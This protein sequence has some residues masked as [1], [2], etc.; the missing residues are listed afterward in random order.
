MAKKSSTGTIFTVAL[1][2]VGGYFAYENWAAISAW[3]NTIIPMPTAGAATAS[4]FY[5][6]SPVPTSYSTSQTFVD[7][8]GNQWQFST[9]TGAWVIAAPGPTAVSPSAGT[10]VSTVPQ[11]V[12]APAAAAPVTASPVVSVAQP[13]APLVQW[14]APSPAPAAPAS[15]GTLVATGPSEFPTAPIIVTSYTTPPGSTQPVATRVNP[16]YGMPHYRGY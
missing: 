2:G 9:Q 14:G 10:V 11:P 3:I 16:I 1:L 8:S 7:S 12:A 4:G 13:A 5:P 15:A 6:N